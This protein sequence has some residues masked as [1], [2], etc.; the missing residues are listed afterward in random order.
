MKLQRAI[1]M[2]KNEKDVKDNYIK[3]GGLV[4]GYTPEVKAKA[5][6]EKVIAEVIEEAPQEPVIEPIETVIEE[7]DESTEKSFL[8]KILM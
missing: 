1:A 6:Q 4:E 8:G 2:S 5:K 3:I 7:F